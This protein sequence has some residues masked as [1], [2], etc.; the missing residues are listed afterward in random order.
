MSNT[1]QVGDRILCKPYKYKGQ[2]GTVRYFGP[3][4][5]KFGTWV[6]IELDVSRFTSH[7]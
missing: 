1:Y 4:N 3:L 6:G 2:I 5:K 7:S